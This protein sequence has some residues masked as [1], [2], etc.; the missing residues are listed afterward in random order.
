[1][2]DILSAT[3]F[4]VL[5]SASFG[6]SAATVVLGWW[7]VLGTYSHLEDPKN[8]NTWWLVMIGQYKRQLIA[9][10][11]LSAVSLTASIL[12]EILGRHLQ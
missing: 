1:M 2:R 3:L 11:V 8:P 10:S 5:F 7:I 6:G 9:F 4:L 12:L